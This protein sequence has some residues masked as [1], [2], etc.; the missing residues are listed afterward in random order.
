MR[1]QIQLFS[2][3]YVPAPDHVGDRN[4]ARVVALN[5]YISTLGYT[6]SGD[7]IRALA[8]TPQATFSVIATRLSETLADVSGADAN[9]NNVL[10]KKFP[11]STPDQHTYLMNRVTGHMNNAFGLKPNNYAV[12]SCGHVIDHNQF[13]LT[14]FGACPI[15]QRQ[16]PELQGV[17]SPPLHDFASI[18]PLKILN[19]ATAETVTGQISG[20]LARQSSLKPDEKVFLNAFKYLRL[21]VER[22]KA[23]Y[24]ENLPF[25]HVYFN[26]TSYTA[27]MLSGATDV[28]RIATFLS[29]EDGDL[30]LKD[31][32]KFKLTTSQKKQVLRLLEA[33]AS[34]DNFLED[35][36]RHRERWLRVAELL[37][38]MSQENKRKYPKMSAAFDTLRADP[39]SIQTFGKIVEK[40]IRSK[41][42]DP[43]LLATL[44]TRPGEF[45]RRLDNLLRI[46]ATTK[47]KSA[48][49][50]DAIFAALHN[51]D[52]AD[53][54]V[55]TTREVLNAVNVILP[56]LKTTTLFEMRKYFIHRSANTHEDRM[57]FPKGSVSKVQIV[58]DKRKKIAPEVTSEL[59]TAFESEII[60]RFSSTTLFNGVVNDDLKGVMIPFGA[61]SASSTN[62]ALTRG[63]RYPVVDA[64]T[65]RMFIYWKNSSDV[66]LSL[67][68][69][70]ENFNQIEQISY[71][72]LAAT[73]AVHSGDI[74]SAP[75][76]AS[77]YIDFDIARFKKRGI[78][79]VAMS[80]IS[81]TGIPFNNFKCF[82]GYMERDALRSGELFEPESVAVKMTV[83]TPTTSNIPLLFDLETCE[84]IYIDIAG[85]NSRY[86]A[87]ADQTNKFMTL[88]KAMVRLPDR[89][90]TAHD[91]ITLFAKANYNPDG[92]TVDF[93]RASTPLDS[94]LKLLEK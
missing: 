94:V 81:Y 58:P 47:K 44:S 10:F 86:G 19:L 39:K 1:E 49:A 38:T 65:I 42:I 53:E 64:S 31:K 32:V 69:Y 33:S 78:R 80:V 23:V 62:V 43:V 50:R 51:A 91:V 24:R 67:L 41:T 22:P 48:V 8:I 68:A 93:S 59:V 63:S 74:Q 26:D 4:D 72:N 57:F 77:E 56:N 90:V 84:M 52:L 30:S 11:Y 17:T 29:Q 73:G 3:V 71:H 75:D 12:L 55:P 21:P 76:G 60:N 15:C 83:T 16:V 25:V 34:N 18:T 14:E 89:K 37:A 54:S 66:D 2:E 79:Y 35:L 13:D 82:A 85:A 40:G 9:T 88:T 36:M 27:S 28:L 6:L 46:A 92:P 87:V 5:L 61:R 45:M 20:M 7:L 70:D